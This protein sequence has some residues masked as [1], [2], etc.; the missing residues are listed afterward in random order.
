MAMARWILLVPVP[1]TLPPAS[2]CRT[3]LV[4]SLNETLFRGPAHARHVI[5]EWRTD[6]N[7]QRSRTSL[8]RLTP[9]EFAERSREDQ[10]RN[11]FWL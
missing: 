9:D 6:D 5:E 1:L 3:A 4:E 11:G 10:N 8:H 2:R 7:I